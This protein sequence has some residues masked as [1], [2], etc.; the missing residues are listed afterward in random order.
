MSAS[1]RVRDES[2]R[3]RCER[4]ALRCSSMMRPSTISISFNRG[5][6]R[7]AA[8]VSMLAAPLLLVLRPALHPILSACIA[9]IHVCNRF[10][11]VAT[12]LAMYLTAELLFV[13]TPSRLPVQVAQGAIVR[14]DWALNRLRLLGRATGE[15]PGTA[16]HLLLLAPF[17]LPILQAHTT[18]L[19]WPKAPCEQAKQRQ[20]GEWKGNET[21]SH[22]PRAAHAVVST[23]THV[24][25][26][27]LHDEFTLP[28]AHVLEANIRGVARLAWLVH[29]AHKLNSMPTTLTS[30]ACNAPNVGLEYAGGVSRPLRNL[31]KNV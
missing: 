13:Q 23:T 7:G 20:Q 15:A 5:S 4:S 27:W 6:V 29:G 31:R 16:S 25:H 11:V 26:L 9:I 30:Q 28:S 8:M 12:A 2:L 3:R 14:V 22:V 17:N 24:L 18:L 1:G 19:D 10:L 21:T